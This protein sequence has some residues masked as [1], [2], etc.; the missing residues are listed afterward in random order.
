[1]GSSLINVDFRHADLSNSVF[2]HNSFQVTLYQGT[3]MEGAAG[4]VIGP[5]VLV[6]EG[7]SRALGGPE[8]EQWIRNRGGS[9]HV[10][11]LARQGQD[12]DPFHGFGCRLPR[13]GSLV[14]KMGR[15]S[16][17][18]RMLRRVT[19]CA[20]NTEVPP[21]RKLHVPGRGSMM[22]SPMTCRYSW[23]SL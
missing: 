22:F 15:S 10:V 5:V 6:Y 20:S 11:S 14:V 21:A 2:D 16:Q 13:W 12:I 17:P 23:P 7:C 9:I 3:K 8:L 4:T 18:R 1:M 19:D